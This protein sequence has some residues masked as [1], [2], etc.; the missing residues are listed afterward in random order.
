MPSHPPV[1]SG[2]DPPQSSIQNEIVVTEVVD[3]IGEKFCCV[4]YSA[5]GSLRLTYA[6]GFQVFAKVLD[7]N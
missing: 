6:I 7:S 1:E 2:A 4:R 5:D 3:D